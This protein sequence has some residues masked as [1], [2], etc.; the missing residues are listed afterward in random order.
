LEINFVAKPS[1][2]E[3]L[4]AKPEV[5]ISK[6]EEKQNAKKDPFCKQLWGFRRSRAVTGIG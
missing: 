3:N 2:T 6:R 4:Y 1:N 5:T